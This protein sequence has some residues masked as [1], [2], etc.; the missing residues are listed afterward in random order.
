MASGLDTVTS[1]SEA[2]SPS[3]P[4]VF[5]FGACGLYGV[6]LAGVGG[7]QIVT[8]VPEGYHGRW[9]GFLAQGLSMALLCG[10]MVLNQFGVRRTAWIMMGLS[11]ISIGWAFSILQES[12]P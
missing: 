10:A 4:L 11:F 5:L 3:W 2:G 1:S 6:Y 9:R 8:G 12:L 7:W